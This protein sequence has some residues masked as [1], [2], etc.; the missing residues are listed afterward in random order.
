M[1]YSDLIIP[2][3]AITA[4]T[5]YL[6]SNK[7]EPSNSHTARTLQAAASISELVRHLTDMRYRSHFLACVVTV[8]ALIHF[9][10]WKG[11]GPDDEVAKQSVRLDIGVMKQFS[12]VWPL[13]KVVLTQM[14]NAVS[15]ILKAT[16]FDMIGR[17][18]DAAMAIEL[19]DDSWHE[20]YC[21]HTQ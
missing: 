15:A 16:E 17:Q 20:M 8:A 5:P 7:G 21:H 1:P 18:S 19:A 4:C 3:G 12:Q 10:N 6:H 14:K 11:L 2:T 13:A 9:G